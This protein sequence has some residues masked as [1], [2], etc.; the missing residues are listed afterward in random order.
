MGVHTSTCAPAYTGMCMIGPT[1][2]DLRITSVSCFT[3]S[4]TN[5]RD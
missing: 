3:P 2:G 5:S 4:I 1:G